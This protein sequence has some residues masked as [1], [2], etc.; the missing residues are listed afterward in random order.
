MKN[1]KVYFYGGTAPVWR[2]N[3][4]HIVNDGNHLFFYT[5]SWR[6]KDERLATEN[7]IKEL[8]RSIFKATVIT[9]T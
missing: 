6:N 5:Q 9:A 2:I 7:E 4:L 3:K 1:H 8:V